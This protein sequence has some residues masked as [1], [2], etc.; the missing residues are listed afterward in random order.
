MSETT[1]TPGQWEINEDDYG[2]EHWFGGEGRGEIRVGRWVTG[3]C[4]D[5]PE[6][7]AKRQYEARLVSVSEQML[8]E[9]KELLEHNN[10]VREDDSHYCFDETNIRALIAKVEGGQ[11]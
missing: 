6:E 4:K 1:H 8:A 10:W 7:W 11:A 2:D 3:G 9:L 5:N